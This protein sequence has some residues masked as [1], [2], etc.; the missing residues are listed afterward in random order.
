MKVFLC[1]IPEEQTN[2]YYLTDERI[3][4]TMPNGKNK[5]G[6]GT[7]IVATFSIVSYAFFKDVVLDLDPMLTFILIM[8]VGVS[9]GG[10]ISFFTAKRMDMLFNRTA[11]MFKGNIEFLKELSRRG[12][13][14][15]YELILCV[16]IVVTFLLL[17]IILL[18]TIWE[19]GILGLV[20]GILLWG[21]CTILINTLI[22]TRP[23]LRI[24]LYKQLNE[25]DLW[26]SYL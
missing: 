9:I 6:I 17:N 12:K 5:N 7:S 14:Q 19:N 18:Q 15:L 3:V 26:D 21:I 23:I 13:K 20:S 16:I 2:Y 10:G 1:Y 4:Y 24:R 11:I 8:V 22:Y 25:V